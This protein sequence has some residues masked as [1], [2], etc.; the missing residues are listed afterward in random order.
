MTEVNITGSLIQEIAEHMIEH[1]GRGL[2]TQDWLV[3]RLM[4]AQE[5][6]K[7]P[8]KRKLEHLALALCS[9]MLCEACV[10]SDTEKQNLG[11]ENLQRVLETALAR[12]AI[13]FEQ[14]EEVVQQT[15]LEIWGII[16]RRGVGPDQ[17]AAFLKWASVILQRQLFHQIQTR[18]DED[19]IS[20]EME[21]RPE[22]ELLIDSHNS[23]PLDTVVSGE[24]QIELK[25]AISALK[26][27]Q[28]RQV[29]LCT[30]FAEIGE[31][32][33]AERLKV[34]V[35]EIYLWR[36][37]ALRALHKTGAFGASA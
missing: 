19:S 24:F 35:Q 22:L 6:H 26:N 8:D 13:P 12:R 21:A 10:S 14:R 18:R 23:D 2:L 15:L 4:Q 20:L 31:R 36:F 33:L 25:K 16:Q 37:R 17:P 7:E 34:S 9:Q 11:F 3:T 5:E 30:L 32:E 28:Y 27:P 29:L 1:Y